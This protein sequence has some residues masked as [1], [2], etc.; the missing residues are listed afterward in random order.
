[1][2][3]ILNEFDKHID[4]SCV[5]T[6]WR[7]GNSMETVFGMRR[8]L[9]YRRYLQNVSTQALERTHTHTCRL[10]PS[11]I[12][13][14]FYVSDRQNL[15]PWT[16][17]AVLNP[18]LLFVVVIGYQVI[19]AGLPMIWVLIR[20]SLCMNA[21][22]LCAGWCSIRLQQHRQHR[23]YFIREACFSLRTNGVFF[24]YL[25]ILCQSINE[26]RWNWWVERVCILKKK[27][28]ENVWLCLLSRLSCM[29]IILVHHFVE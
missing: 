20:I 15:T 28:L 14:L 3:R 29:Y 10:C 19:L 26:C 9:I 21:G 11:V 1:M 25:S 17:N 7:Y 22:Q 6:D 5:P 23:T 8:D 4:Y 12:F 27:I 2:P 18:M 16:G 24:F 13:P